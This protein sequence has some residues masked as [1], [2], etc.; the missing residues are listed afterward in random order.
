MKKT[1]FAI[2]FLYLF[3]A[4]A[5][6]AT[7]LVG[8]DSRNGCRPYSLIAASTANPTVVK[9]SPGQIYGGYITNINA[10]QAYVKLYNKATT[11]LSTDTPVQRWLIPGA[12]T[13][14]GSVFSVPPG[15]EL[16]AGISFRIT[17]GVADNDV[18]AVTANEVLVNFCTK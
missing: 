17:T 3:A 8:A 18:G 7:V 9:A 14:G 15:I 2:I 12:T 6:S 16:T 11:P 4:K 5:F 10:A 13:G 1:F